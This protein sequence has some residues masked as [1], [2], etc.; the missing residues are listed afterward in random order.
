MSSE[1]RSSLS[2]DREMSRELS[3]REEHEPDL[4]PADGHLC[5][6]CEALRVVLFDGS[7]VMETKPMSGRCR[8]AR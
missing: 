4:I 5:E 1:L 8:Q 6:L 2:E 3:E 7:S